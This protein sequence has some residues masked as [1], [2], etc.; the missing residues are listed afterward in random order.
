VL[1][2]KA[3][4]FARVPGA[5]YLQADPALPE[6]WEGVADCDAAINLA[7][8][9][10]QGRWTP[11][12]KVSIR[13]SRVA[14]TRNLV[15]AIPSDRPFTLVS[16]SAV[17]IYGDAGERECTEASGPGRDFLAS[18][19]R[20]WEEEARKAEAKGARVLIT[21]FAVVLGPHGGALRPLAQLTRSCLGGPLAGGRQWFSWIH[22]DDLIAA[23]HFLLRQ[24]ALRGTFNFG[25]PTP[26][27]QR[28][29]ARALGRALRRPARTPTPRFALRLALGEAADLVLFSQKMIPARLAEQGFRWK[30]EQLDA[31]LRSI[32]G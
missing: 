10:I 31:A 29:F 3:E 5:E 20:D 8:E 26:V 16:T 22:L 27:R 25:A 1:V 11:S 14:T 30:F 24:E 13:E 28:D 18:V 19:A 4:A 2:R 12:K 9:P 6:A 32:F 15:A 17:G 21:R 23:Q 7:G